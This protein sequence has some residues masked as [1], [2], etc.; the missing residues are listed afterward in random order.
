MA[1]QGSSNNS[2]QNLGRRA[3]E[4]KYVSTGSF[5]G[6]VFAT[7]F[8]TSRL[9][10]KSWLGA[11]APFCE[12]VLQLG[13][14]GEVMALQGVWGSG[15]RCSG[16]EGV[17]LVLIGLVSLAVQRFRRLGSRGLSTGV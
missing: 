14:L 16:V 13:E 12:N 17:R 11:F 4:E 1:T 3:C 6:L 2:Y 5:R 9:R 15:F 8:R 10:C 7:F